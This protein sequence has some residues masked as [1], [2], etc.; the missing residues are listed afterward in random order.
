M[1]NK[2][3]QQILQGNSYLLLAILF[4]FTA[5]QLYHPTFESSPFY[6]SCDTKVQKNTKVYFYRKSSFLQRDC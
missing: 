6:M 3:D 5:L 2:Y 1:I 4:P